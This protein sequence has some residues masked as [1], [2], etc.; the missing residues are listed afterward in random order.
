LLENGVYN[1]YNEFYD[2]EGRQIQIEGIEPLYSTKTA[3]PMFAVIRP[4]IYNNIIGSENIPLGISVFENVTDIINGIDITYDSLINEFI[5]GKKRIFI[6][7]EMIKQREQNG[8][9]LFDSRDVTFY[10]L[11]YLTATA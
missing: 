4:G 2:K 11:T 3:T 10:G 5:L 6:S 7:E 1:V 8:Q 9:P